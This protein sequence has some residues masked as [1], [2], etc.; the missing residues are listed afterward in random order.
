MGLK[1]FSDNIRGPQVKHPDLGLH[2][3]VRRDH[4][5]GKSAQGGVRLPFLH[6][7]ITVPD[8]HDQV[9]QHDCDAVPVLAHQKQRLFTVLRL[10]HVVI[11]LKNTAQDS[12]VDLHVVRHQYGVSS[13]HLIPSSW[14]D[15]SPPAFHMYILPANPGQ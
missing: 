6:H 14:N 11:L 4:R 5:H 13:V 7:L 9:Q 1:G 2:T 8:R 12:A 15:P 10:Q 3:V